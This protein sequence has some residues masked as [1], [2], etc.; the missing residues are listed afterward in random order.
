MSDTPISRRESLKRAAGA[1]AL[2]LGAPAALAATDSNV[3]L[4]FGKIEFYKNRGGDPAGY[5]EL[6][7]D[8]IGKLSD[9]EGVIIINKITFSD[10]ERRESQSFD[11][12]AARG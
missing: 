12:R 6:P 8:L 1:L 10:S 9:E 4:V 3:E 7:R 11:V 5:V 2:G